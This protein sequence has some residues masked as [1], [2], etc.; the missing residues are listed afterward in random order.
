M[1]GVTATGPAVPWRVHAVVE[2]SAANGPGTRFVV[3]SQG[4][5]LACPGCF[6]PDTHPAA[7]PSAVRT[8]G[9]LVE[10]A[11][12]A[13]ADLDGV[14]LTGGEPL[15]QPAAA[16]AFCAGIRARSGLG[17]IV[18]TGFTRREIEADPAR[19]A[20]VADADLVVA[21]R[22]NRRLHLARGLRGSSNKEYWQRTGRYRAEQ[23]S[24]VPELEITIEDD[25]TL[26]F[27]GMAA[28]EGDF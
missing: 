6:N 5:T 26:V 11:L 1:A 7:G 20:A 22:Y 8:A 28:P 23:M 2:R 24:D 19:A 12:A 17:V 13:G 10:Q 27:S 9:E 3:W 16:A 4:C 18:L 14:T 21:G 25:A 15:E